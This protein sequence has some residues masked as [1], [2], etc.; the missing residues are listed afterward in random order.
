MKVLPT[1]RRKIDFSINIATKDKGDTAE[2]LF[3]HH[4][5]ILA[6]VFPKLAFVHYF[7]KYVS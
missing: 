4:M 2:E 1:S 7:A 3:D 6:L 5:H